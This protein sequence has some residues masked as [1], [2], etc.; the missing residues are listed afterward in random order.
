[1]A[2]NALLESFGTPYTWRGEELVAL[3]HHCL[4]DL[5][6]ALTRL[7]HLVAAVACSS[8]LLEEVRFRRVVDKMSSSVAV[9][10]AQSSRVRSAVAALIRASQWSEI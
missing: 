9:T 8:Y 3:L 10:S 5:N 6:P 2:K 1:M 7:E 4:A